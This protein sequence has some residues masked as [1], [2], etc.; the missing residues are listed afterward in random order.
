[1]DGLL[2]LWAS[3]SLLDIMSIENAI[4]GVT[5]FNEDMLGFLNLQDLDIPLGLA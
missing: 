4:N 2:K 5:F 1:M 3:F